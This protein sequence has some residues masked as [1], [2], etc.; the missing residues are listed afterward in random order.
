MTPPRGPRRPPATAVAAG[1]AAAPGEAAPSL[2]AVD[3]LPGALDDLDLGSLG[4]AETG[5]G[6]DGDI[7][8][9]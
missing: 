4:D 7:P 3:P 8:S 1:A 9:Y 2:S 5:L 6:R